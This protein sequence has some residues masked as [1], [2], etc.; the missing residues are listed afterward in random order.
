MSYNQSDYIQ[1]AIESCFNTNVNYYEVIV[2]DDA[3]DKDS[4]DLDHIDRFICSI[5]SEGIKYRI[6][7]NQT[8]LGSVGSLNNVLPLVN[9]PYFTILSGDDVIILPGISKLLSFA[10]DGEYDLVGGNFMHL[11][12][13]D[14]L[15]EINNPN[16]NYI[17]FNELSSME[18]YR[19]IARNRLPF[20]RGGA[21]FK[22]SKAL[23]VGLFDD[24]F[25]LY[26]DR[27]MY[28][29]MAKCGAKFAKLDI[30]VYGWRN[31]S[32]A[33]SNKKNPGS[34]RFLKDQLILYKDEYYV[35]SDLL[36]FNEIELSRIIKKYK[37]IIDYHEKKNNLIMLFLFSLT[38]F[39]SI[40]QHLFLKITFRS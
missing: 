9:T 2:V 1:R 28:L 16:F 40:V 27:P 24:R 26:D 4:F 15:I 12:K 21:I 32:G 19:Y 30:V 3:S 37:L 17:N 38:N 33:S 34:I 35:N 39:P 11:D 5:N 25:D 13:D 20:S 6:F 14:E 22:L 10:L 18:K 29:R 36:G 7:R 23:D 8:N 31:Y